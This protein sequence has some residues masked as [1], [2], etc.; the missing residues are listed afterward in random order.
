VSHLNEKAK[1]LREEETS[2]A[3]IG[4]YFTEKTASGKGAAAHNND[5]T[6]FGNVIA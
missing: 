3:A 2:L 6:T 1:T 4:Q 5:H